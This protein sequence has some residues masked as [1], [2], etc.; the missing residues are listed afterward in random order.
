MF[1]TTKQ[2]DIGGFSWFFAIL[3]EYDAIVYYWNSVFFL[4]LGYD[5]CMATWNSLAMYPPI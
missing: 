4:Q 5:K 1:Q 3:Q 2:I